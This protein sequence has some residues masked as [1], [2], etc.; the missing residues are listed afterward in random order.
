MR[1]IPFGVP[2]QESPVFDPFTLR[3]LSDAFEQAWQ[4]VQ[5][6]G[7]AETHQEETRELLAKCIIER[8]KLGD[9]N[10]DRLR[11]AALIHFAEDK[12]CKLHLAEVKLR[13]RRS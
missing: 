13:K 5:A 7:Q 3:I 12:L 1:T 6:S 10:K 11:Q 2:E 8:A 4:S 9:R